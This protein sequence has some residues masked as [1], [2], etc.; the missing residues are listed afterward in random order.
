MMPQ[1][2]PEGTPMKKQLLSINDLSILLPEGSDRQFA[3]QHAEL[4]LHAGETVCV[5]GERI[6]QISYSPCRD[7]TLPALHVRLE[8]VR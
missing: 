8:A 6:W 3:V 1:S 4:Q 5:V 7:G 2:T